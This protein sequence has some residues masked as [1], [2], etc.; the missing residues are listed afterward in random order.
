MDIGTNAIFF[1]FAL[2]EFVEKHAIL[3]GPSLRFQNGI[4]TSLLGTGD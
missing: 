3:L 1:L 2:A 4:D